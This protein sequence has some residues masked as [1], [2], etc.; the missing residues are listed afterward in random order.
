MQALYADLKHEPKTKPK[1]DGQGVELV[2]S[3]EKVV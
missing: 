3:L 1:E 2:S